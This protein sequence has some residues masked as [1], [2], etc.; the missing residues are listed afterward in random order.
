MPA[1]H[2]PS[3]VFPAGVIDTLQFFQVVYTIREIMR[4]HTLAGVAEFLESLLFTGVIAFLKFG[5]LTANGIITHD[6]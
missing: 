1:T 5:Q 4:K 2:K 6:A 3:I